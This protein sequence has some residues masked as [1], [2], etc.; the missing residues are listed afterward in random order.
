MFCDQCEHEYDWRE[1]EKVKA[2]R[3]TADDVKEMEF[4][5]AQHDLH[6]QLIDHQLS[7]AEVS[8]EPGHQFLTY[9]TY[10]PHRDEYELDEVDLF[11]DDELSR[12]YV[13]EDCEMNITRAAQ[14]QNK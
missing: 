3:Q 13:D 7:A 11:D 8:H 1:A 12:P 9:V 4:F 6:F 14:L 10:E 5:Q 2:P